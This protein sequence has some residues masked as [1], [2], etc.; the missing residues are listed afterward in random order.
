MKEKK[1]IC[2]DPYGNV[3]LDTDFLFRENKKAI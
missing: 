1:V 3:Y 2:K